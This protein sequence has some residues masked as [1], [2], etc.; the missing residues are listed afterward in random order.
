MKEKKNLEIE[1][2]IPNLKKKEIKEEDKK[3]QNDQKWVWESG[4]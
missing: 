1:K 2:E 4:I 3:N